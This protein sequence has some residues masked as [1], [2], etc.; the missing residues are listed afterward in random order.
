MTSRI[1]G[2]ETSR[3]WRMLRT[4]DV[5]VS[6]PIV[7][8]R[9]AGRPVH[10]DRRPARSCRRQLVATA[11]FTAVGGGGRAVR[12]VAG[13]VAFPASHHA[14]RCAPCSPAMARVRRGEALRRT[15]GARERS[16]DRRAGRRLQPHAGR[17]PRARRAARGARAEPRGRVRARTVD[18]AGR[19]RCGRGRQPRQVGFPR[20]DEP[21]NP[22]ADERHHGDGGPARA[23]G[24]AAPPAALRRVIAAS[25]K[26]LL[27]IINDILDF[28]KI[29]AGKLELERLPVD[30]N[31]LA[32][33]VTSLFAER[34]RKKDLDLAAFVDPRVRADD[35]ADP[36]RLG[37]VVSNLVNN[38]LKFTERGFGAPEPS[39]P[40]RSE[41]VRELRCRHRHRDRQGQ[42]RF[43]L[44]VV[45]AG[46]PEHDTQFRRAPGSG[47]TISQRLAD[48]LGG[49]ITV[50]SELGKSS[51]F[52]LVLPL[53]GASA[54]PCCPGLKGEKATCLID[55]AGHAS[56][57]A[58]TAIFRGLGLYDHRARRAGPAR[59]RLRRRG[60]GREVSHGRRRADP[61]CAVRPGRRPRGRAARRAQGR[62]LPDP[63]GAA[64]RNRD[65]AHAHRRRRTRSP[66]GQSPA[67]R[68][69]P[70]CGASAR[71]S[72]TTTRSIGRSRSRRS[73]N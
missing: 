9:D 40:C 22:H 71:S 3:S 13:G 21:R 10:P 57:A 63:A 50:E 1:A 58:L 53:D 38:A 11:A 29:E 28:S 20:H 51:T 49:E 35:H 26:S 6:V 66:A 59:H 15:V 2:E 61:D 48:A 60:Q 33:N 18:L 4:R 37:Q 43:D 67:P 55:V 73:R 24:P 16:R 42:A 8:Q 69:S 41:W 19:A 62:C 70:R 54:V 39:T 7:G 32:E 46:G 17:H 25:G 68:R 34:A 5:E 52:S 64:Q 36:V 65:A 23:G 72:R 30:V 14:G 12:R 56:R 31:A 47:S 44:R 27:A 45:L